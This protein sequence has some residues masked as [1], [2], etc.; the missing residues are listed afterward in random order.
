[1]A[2]R[3]DS[4]KIPDFS[5]FGN[6]PCS[7]VDPEI[8]FPVDNGEEIPR[9]KNGKTTY[10][11]VSRYTNEQGAKSVCFKCPYKAACLEYAINDY[12]LQGI[13]GGTNEAQ[14]ATI[15]RQ[16]RQIKKAQMR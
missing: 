15:R 11:V 6:P 4:I 9:T 14:R 3:D 13:W 1:M 2:S 8:F 12:T 7:E 16:K 5:E 10:A